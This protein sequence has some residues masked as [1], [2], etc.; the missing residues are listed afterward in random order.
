MRELE[1]VMFQLPGHEDHDQFYTTARQMRTLPRYEYKED[2]GIIEVDDPVW[3]KE[4]IGNR[5]GDEIFLEFFTNPM[6]Q[7]A[8]RIEQLT[9]PKH[10]ATMPGSTDFYRWEHV[11]GSVIFVRKMIAKAEAEGQVFDPRDVLIMQLRTFVSDLG[12]TAFSHL[13]DWMFQGF[14]GKEDQH[15][16]DLMDLLELGGVNQ[17]LLRHEID[18]REVVFPPVEDWIE[19]PSPDLCVDR[20]DFGAREI[21]R[22]VSGYEPHEKWL[23]RFML[24]SSGRIVMSDEAE[25]LYFGVRYGLLA[26]EHWGHPV[27]RAQL[28]L[29]AELVRSVVVNRDTPIIGWHELQHPRDIL[30][31]VDDDIIAGSRSVGEL[32]HDL[33]SVML[34]IARAQRR[35]FAHGRESELSLFLE[36]FRIK[37]QDS[38]FSFDLPESFPHPLQARHWTTD[39]TGSKPINLSF[40]PVNEE[41]DLKDFNNLPHTLDVYLPALKPRW[42][43]PLFYDNEGRVKRLSE[44][45]KV[46]ADLLRQQREIQSQPYVARYYADPEFLGQLKLKLN[47]YLDLW[48]EQLKAKRANETTMRAVL[49]DAGALAIGRSFSGIIS[50]L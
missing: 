44:E 21:G 28:H 4:Q 24:D 43:D 27:H 33:Y 45:N 1:E 16:L 38:K 37:I 13:G 42:V 39:Y 7:R 23:E 35:I 30:Y 17:I 25:A 22:W 8:A 20:V 40:V 31:T 26:T 19:S 10:F 14:G 48:H 36:P 47:K 11:W 18:P 34:D 15:D 32:N 6:V 49:K 2:L 46:Y 50:S 3:G 41:K 12:H 9:L 29:F 5:K